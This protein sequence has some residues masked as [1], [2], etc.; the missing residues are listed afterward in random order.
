MCDWI[1]EALGPDVPVHFTAFHPDFRLRDR[2]RTPAETLL[3]AYDMAR[4]RGLNYVYVGNIQAPP[5][6]STYCPNCRQAAD[7]AARLRPDRVSDAGQP[8]RLLRHAESPDTSMP[9]PGTWGSRRLPVRISAYSPQVESGL[10]AGRLETDYDVQS[11][12]P[13][14]RFEPGQLGPAG[15]RAAQRRARAGHPALGRLQLLAAATLEQPL[16]LGR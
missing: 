9:A 13:S 3:A 7:R 14:C 2:P 6:H 12:E 15:A 10:A 8:V 1:L 16:K 5:Q 4:R 11:S